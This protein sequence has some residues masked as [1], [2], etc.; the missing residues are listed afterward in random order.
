[1]IRL[2]NVTFEISLGKTPVVVLEQASNWIEPGRYAL[3]VENPATRNPVIDLLCGT[4]AP[5]IGR[6]ERSGR[7]SWPIGR[8]GFIRGHL[9][10]WDVV[11]MICRIYDLNYSLAEDLISDLIPNVESLRS[12]VGRF[13]PTERMEFTYALALLPKFDIYFLEGSLGFTNDQFAQLWRLLFEDRVKDR[14][15]VVSSYSSAVV[16]GMCDKALC[17]ARGSLTIDDRLDAALGRYPL[18]AP[19]P[20]GVVADEEDPVADDG[21]FI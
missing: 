4:R 13:T 12:P 14:M 15:L 19:V 5:R 18:R 3:L 11:A 8:V 17:V 21:D 7:A 16:T 6:V 9:T 20:G 10:G 1:M 2:R